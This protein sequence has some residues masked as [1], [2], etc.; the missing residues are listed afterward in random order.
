[1]GQHSAPR[2]RPAR[3]AAE[4]R[5][6]LMRSVKPRMSKTQA[7]ITFLFLL[8][9]FTTTSAIVDNEADALLS[10]T[11]QSD[12]VGVL[13][14]LAQREARLR[15][16]L[17]S[18]ENDRETLLGGD[19]Y[20]ALNA[21]KERAK[22]LALIAGTEPATGSGIVINISGTLSAVTLLD[23]IQELRDAGA[24]AIE[25]SDANLN[26]RVVA[27]TW[28]ADAST[29]VNISG[30]TLTL[31]IR[32]SVIGDSTVLAPALEIPGGLADT[33]TTGGGSITLEEI[34]NISIKSVVPL[35]TS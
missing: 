6:R 1:M 34:E 33:V 15:Q 7:T 16:E 35:A 13:D 14:N 32:I 4:A 18:L 20:A 17:I 24:K 22:A 29:G 9:G 12:L 25:V 26:V 23:A 10:G 30:T 27:N 11:R 19:E 21:A 28:F 5:F 31:P 2:H 3:T 8:L